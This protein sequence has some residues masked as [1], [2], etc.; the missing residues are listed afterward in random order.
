MARQV[1]TTSVESADPLGLDPTTFTVTIAVHRVDGG[2]LSDEELATA[3]AALA[4][5]AR[6]RGAAPQPPASSL[7]VAEQVAALAPLTAEIRAI[8]TG[9][10]PAAE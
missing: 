9:S 8:A 1:F 7:S 10:K 5:V 6:P 3:R 2:P 4:R